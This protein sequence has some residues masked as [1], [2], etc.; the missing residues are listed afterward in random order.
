MTTTLPPAL[1]SY[2]DAVRRE[3]TSRGARA[4]DPNA[5]PPGS[6][7]ALCVTLD[8]VLPHSRRLL[9]AGWH[10]ELGWWAEPYGQTDRRYLPGALVPEPAEVADFLTLA[11]RAG[12]CRPVLH[13]YRLLAGERDLLARLGAGR[14]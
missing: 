12:S 5:H 14:G 9:R 11:G 13:R 10:E 7:Q 4:G 1:A 3:L 2:L 8:L 6:R